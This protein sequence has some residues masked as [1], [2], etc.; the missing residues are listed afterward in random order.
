[1][2]IEVDID[3]VPLLVIT[4]VLILFLI[5]RRKYLI[6]RIKSCFQDNETK[7]T[8]STTADGDV[9][10]ET[11]LLL[12][13]QHNLVPAQRSLLSY[14][15][16][17]WSNVLQFKLNG[18]NV[19]IVNPQPGELLAHYIR[20]KA[21]LKGTKLGCEEG[22]C[23]ACSVIVEKS[24]GQVVAANSC[25]RLLCLNDGMELTTVEGLG[26]IKTSL[27]EEQQQIVKYSATQCGFCTPGW[28]TAMHALREEA[29]REGKPLRK[30]DVDKK[31]DGN[32]C[33][34]TG[35]RPI[36]QAFH[37]LCSD[38]SVKNGHCESLEEVRACQD[39][40]AD[41]EDLQSCPK[42]TANAA[43]ALARSR[44]KSN[45]KQ[46]KNQASRPLRFHDPT[47]GQSYLRP[48]ALDQL[49]AVL[50]EHRSQYSKHQVQL[51]A[52]NTSI[53][54]S[55]YLNTSG[56]YYQ[57]DS[58]RILVDIN[59]ISEMQEQTFFPET[60]EII[61]GAALSVTEVI[62]A[63]H[64]HCHGNDGEAI[65]HK[66]VFSVT[67]YHLHRVGNTQLRNCA[68]WAGNLMLFLQY[69]GF[70]SDI[71]LVL[72]AARA[73][74][75][76]CDNQGSISYMPI[77]NFLTA[78]WDEFLQKGLFIVALILREPS[79]VEGETIMETFKMARRE[80]N[81]HA[82]VDVACH[83][84]LQRD[85]RGVP[86][87]KSARIVLGAVAPQIFIAYRAEGVVQG[88]T[89]NAATL[90]AALSALQ[91]DWTDAGGVNSELTSYAFITSATPA[92]LYR[93]FLRCFPKHLVPSNLQ[94]VLT[95]WAKPSSHGVEFYPIDRNGNPL[96]PIGQAVSKIEA[97]IQATGEAVYPSDETLSANCLHA[98]IVFSTRA[99]VTLQAL[100]ASAALA[101]RGVVAMYTAADIPGANATGTGMPL[102][103]P[104]GELVPCAGAPLAVIVA[105]SE[106]LANRAAA[107]VKV[108][109]GSDA[110][111]VMAPYR[112]SGRL[113][114]AGQSH[115]YMEEAH[116]AVAKLVDGNKVNI[117]FGTQ[118]PSDN[119]ASIASILNVPSSQLEVYCARVGGGFGGKLTGGVVN[120]A[121]AALC[122]LKL[123]RPIRIFNPRTADMNM[124]G[125]REDWLA[126]YEVGIT[127][128]GKIQGLT[129]RFYLDAGA[130]YVDAVGGLFMGMYWA[131]NAYYLPNYRA[132]ALLCYTN[133]PVRTS[134]RAPG[135]VQSTLITEMVI[136]RIATELGIPVRTVQERNFIQNGELAI[137]GQVITDSTLPQVWQKVMT[138]SQY[139]SRLQRIQAFNRDNLWRKR[140]LAAAPVKY[141]MGWSGY[142]AGVKLG[143][144]TTDGR[145]FVTHSGVEI[146]QGINTKVAQA[147]ASALGV[148]LSLVSIERT[149][150]SAVVNGGPTGGS[151]TSEVTVQAALN[152]CAKLN[153][154]IDPY[155]KGTAKKEKMSTDEWINF[156]HTVPTSI[157]LNTEGWYS[158]QQNPNGQFFQYFVYAACVTE[159]ELN[160][161][162]GEVHVLSCELVY[163]C[164]R[165]LNPTVDIGQI[166][167]AIV[168]GI[169]YFFHEKV[170]YA[171][172]TGILKTIGTWE[173]KPPM[174][175]DI[176]SLLNV[177]LIA[178]AYDK[179]SIMGSK[180]T[181]EPPLIVANSA[182]FALKMAIGSARA[183]AGKPGFFDLPVPCTV[184]DRQ[185]ASSVYPQ[186]YIMPC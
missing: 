147:V 159:V 139:D 54:V 19:E 144:R 101:I 79:A 56:P 175:Q 99:A 178:N 80:H 39:R 112:F 78:S 117:V 128:D 118:L 155:R 92:C 42:T 110:G 91:Q 23:G 90:S 49:C 75:K 185:V 93:F 95:P 157:S 161:L 113:S 16:I 127:A 146:G 106:E 66:S 13:S 160:V 18:K 28:V 41:I 119:A 183:D 134:M 105:E 20:E 10:G 61:L 121:S 111:L 3:I 116:A 82:F 109:Y 173:Y 137:C 59:Q 132:D 125:G 179:N 52:G 162:S 25:L 5:W 182:Y 177:T 102:F 171:E 154:R 77:E 140:G 76:L 142:S 97:P 165:S 126:D 86:I 83:F 123:N 63:L 12:T 104:V 167:G 151:G 170:M 11:E 31:M 7:T 64:Q 136:E 180:A 94:S 96:S 62:S 122:A 47:S 40:F 36:M 38:S 115:F 169:G 103:V 29:D 87:C 22:G 60:G 45:R 68:T 164:G 37:S 108:T 69:R 174:A 176:P 46:V 32:I 158:P 143:V 2:Q 51:V 44:G 4:S 57:P 50:R 89:L 33:R 81:A 168:M 98:A 34:C 149:S 72:T 58:Y 15:S 156:L 152:A 84:T 135:V 100:D 53:G 124:Q 130:A 48:V 133:T 71:V 26:S 55:K 141:G 181:G 166:E 17:Q 74:L 85:Q 129:Y 120:A 65:D 114:A 21:F 172:G 131:D 186:R 73:T 14:H 184:D 148:D 35:Y 67:A 88:Q 145:V 27:S 9:G 24:N 107:T 150:T 1:M 153:A 43:L 8:K 163:D 138:R 70:A 30:S 6:S